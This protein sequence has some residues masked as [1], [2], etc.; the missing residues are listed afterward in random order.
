MIVTMDMSTGERI[1]EEQSFQVSEAVL[2]HDWTQV[3]IMRTGLQEAVPEVRR[4]PVWCLPPG[5]ADEF[6]RS[7]YLTQE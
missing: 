5:D 7:V 2:L 1:D 4:R 6:L 3:P